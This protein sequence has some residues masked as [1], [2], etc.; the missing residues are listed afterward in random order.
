MKEMIYL[1]EGKTELELFNSLD[2][3]GKVIELNLWQKSISKI[4]RRFK[5]NTVV[6]VIYDTDV[7]DGIELFHK[8]LRQLKKDNR[9]VGIIQQADNLEDELVRACQSIKKHSQLFNEFNAVSAT[10]FKSNFIKTN[11]TLDK[12]N[13]LGFEPTL[14]WRQVV[15]DRIDREF[16]QFKVSYVDLPKR[17]KT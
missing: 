10:E 1:V 14:L 16:H 8:N 17:T 13:S 5:P 15:N 6:Y 9:L 3:M 11:Q 7:L 2:L 4:Q 12:L